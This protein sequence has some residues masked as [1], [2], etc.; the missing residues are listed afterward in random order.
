MG[1]LQN[2]GNTC[3]LNSLLQLLFSLDEWNSKLTPYVASTADIFIL[4]E[5]RKLYEITRE[6]DVVPKGFI[7]ALHIVTCDKKKSSFF[8]HQQDASE[9]LQFIIECFHNALSKKIEGNYPEHDLRHLCKPFSLV[10]EL[11]Y[12]VS[13][14]TLVSEEKVVS[15]VYQPFFMLELPITSLSLEECIMNYTSPEKIDEPWYQESTKTHIQVTK[16]IQITTLPYYLFVVL[17][18][19][20][21][22]QTKDTRR[23][24]I[25]LRLFD[26][27]DLMGLCN[28]YGG[29]PGGHYT[30]MIRESENIWKHYNDIQVEQMMNPPMDNAYLILFRKN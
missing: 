11:F 24:T 4:D 6:H 2:L 17:K 13:S 30:S 23:V 16:Q 3:F 26:K 12:G 10:N 25:P 15:V 22:N 8:P 28:H 27:Y 19:F 20:H 18:R 14:S 7:Q 29:Y 9:C 5:Y 1:G 21:N